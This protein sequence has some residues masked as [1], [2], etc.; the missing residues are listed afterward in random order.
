MSEIWMI[1]RAVDLRRVQ[2]GSAYRDEIERLSLVFR[3][4]DSVSISGV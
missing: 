1:W 2:G 3:A 4:D